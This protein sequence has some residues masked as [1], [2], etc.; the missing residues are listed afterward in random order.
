[1]YVQEE[2]KNEQTNLVMTRLFL[3]L[4]LALF[5]QACQLQ[6]TPKSEDR[7]PGK[8]DMYRSFYNH[9]SLLIIYGSQDPA[10]TD[11]YKSAAKKLQERLSGGRRP[12][13]VEVQS[14]ENYDLESWKKLPSF[15]IGTTSSHKLLNRISPQLPLKQTPEGFTWKE[16]AFKGE[17]HAYQLSFYPNPDSIWTPLSVVSGNSDQAVLSLLDR[18]TGGRRFR[19]WNTLPIQIFEEKQR[20]ALGD[21]DENWQ[22]DPALSWYFDPNP[23]AVFDKQGVSLS[24]HSVDKSEEELQAEGAA[25]IKAFQRVQDFLARDKALP[26]VSVFLYGSPEIIGMM[27]NEMQE[28]V[29]EDT[30]I[31]KLVHPYFPSHGPE[32]ENLWAIKRLLGEPS[33]QVLEQ[34]LAIYFTEN[35]KQKGYPYWTAKLYRSGDWQSLEELLRPEWE[36]YESTLIK[37]SLSASLVAFLL[38]EWGKEEFL[39]NYQSWNP[40]NGELRKL[41]KK[42]INYLKEDA[43]LHLSENREVVLPT[44]LKGMTFAH[45]GYAVYNG[46]GSTLAY[47][48]LKEIKAHNVNM[49]SIVPYSGTRETQKP[50]PF[51]LSRGAGGEN[52]ISVVYASKAAQE[53]GMKTM[54]KPQI[55]FGGSWPGDMEMQ[56]KE[57]WEMFFKHYRR[58]ISHYALLA[59]IHGFDMLCLGTEFVKATI[60]EPEAWKKLAKDMRKIFSGKI[61]YAANWGEE[62]ENI[63]PGF[64]QELDFLGVDCYYPLSKKDGPDDKDLQKGFAD[65]MKKLKKISEKNQKQIIFTEVG[66]R[67]IPMPWKQPHAEAP[68]DQAT[69]E[70][71]ARC[72]RVVLEAMK[73]QDWQIGLVWWKWPSYMDYGNRSPRSFSP[74]GKQAAKVLKEYYGE[75]M[76]RR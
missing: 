68:D 22:I 5:A 40:T 62:I 54:M 58:W 52:D 42:W 29:V 36:E 20:I 48:S 1:M 74:A 12:L 28:F 75:K 45:E 17:Q 65:T 70:D 2:N 66:F 63:S 35:W 57:D 56:S 50:V 61:T 33:N 34:G 7:D 26:E 51:R 44:Y 69:E 43:E 55:Y 25:C 15:L 39:A 4:L 37:G 47:N 67:S 60:Q 76:G 71:Q 59:E 9:R 24:Q 32:A 46:F 31:H 38:K 10:F 64:T 11:A 3:F 6:G 49:V 14:D 41:N 8:E 21:F 19:L 73:D 16:K 30:A 72:Y 13:T 53:L 18:M 23:P 27:K